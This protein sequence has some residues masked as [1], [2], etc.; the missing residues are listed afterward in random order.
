MGTRSIWITCDSPMP[1]SCYETT[2]GFCDV[3]ASGAAIDLHRSSLW[4]SSSR[5]W[6][7]GDR[8]TVADRWSLCVA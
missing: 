6:A 4:I 3:F 2:H 1:L 7:V 5:D 8:T